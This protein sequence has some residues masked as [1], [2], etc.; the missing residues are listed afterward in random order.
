M[1]ATGD[2]GVLKGYDLMK[3]APG[4]NP[5]AVG[6]Y[7]VMTTSEKLSWMNDLI[8]IVAFEALDPMWMDVGIAIYEWK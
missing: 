4:T 6:L 8:G 1:R 3:M 7:K 5:K 2:M